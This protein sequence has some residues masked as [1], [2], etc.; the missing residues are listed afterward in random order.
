M[1]KQLS[2]TAEEAIAEVYIHHGARVKD[3]KGQCDAQLVELER[4][5]IGGLTV[6]FH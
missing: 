5:R 3:S 2:Q 6:G 4:A 1:V